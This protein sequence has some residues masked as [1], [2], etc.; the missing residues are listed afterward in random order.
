MMRSKKGEINLMY[1]FELVAIVFIIFMVFDAA[2]EFS[3]GKTTGKIIL[4]K[5]ISHMVESMVSFP[6]D[7][8]VMYPKNITDYVVTISNGNN[9][10]TVTE[11]NDST[12]EGISFRFTLPTGYGSSGV[13]NS[14]YACLKK[15]GKFIFLDDCE[16]FV[17]DLRGLTS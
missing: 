12:D 2:W 4:G 11:R 9:L 14:V 15:E 17:T 10:V 16:D 1:I 3:Q 13:A 5:D 6:G 7:S 8:F